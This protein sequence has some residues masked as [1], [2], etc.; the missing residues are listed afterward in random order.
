LKHHKACKNSLEASFI[1]KIADRFICL[2]LFI[3]ELRSYSPALGVYQYG[4]F[5][6]RP[7]LETGLAPKKGWDPHASGSLFDAH[8]KL[9]I[10]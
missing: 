7:V 10:H 4:N 3:M 2:S 6:V 8:A 9:C 1:T 5:L